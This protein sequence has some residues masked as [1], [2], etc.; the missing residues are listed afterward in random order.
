MSHKLT[1]KQVKAVHFLA[2]GC[3]LVDVSHA[4]KLRRET[5]SR[6]KKKPEFNAKFE[7]IMA[8]L[9]EGMRHRLVHLIDASISA[10]E[11]GLSYSDDPKRTQAALNVLKLLGI[12]RI[13]LPDVSEKSPNEPDIT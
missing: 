11:A 8:E 4:L 3:T 10:A 9:R 5:L 7:Q 6:W 12:G 13:L 1:P 2:Q